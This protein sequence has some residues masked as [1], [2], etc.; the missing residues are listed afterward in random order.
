MNA[1]NRIRSLQMEIR[2]LDPAE[3]DVRFQLAADRS[4]AGL[5]VRGRL[6]GPRCAYAST[7]EVAY[8][9]RDAPLDEPNRLNARAIVPEP[10]LW[11][12]ACPFLYEATVELLEDRNSIDAITMTLGLRTIAISGK[13]F[14]LNGKRF[15][16][17]AIAAVHPTEADLVQARK[18]FNAIVLPVSEDARPLWHLCDQVGLGVFGCIAN[19]S[20]SAPELANHA[21]LLGWIVDEQKSLASAGDELASARVPVGLQIRND[22]AHACPPGANFVMVPGRASEQVQKWGIPVIEISTIH[23]GESL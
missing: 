7:V 5:S 16:P 1:T 23:R 22:S 14:V 20:R 21:C 18:Q 19:E 11:E 12:P 6:V 4:D 8:P 15:E 10:N 2:K 13:S 3:A 9:L 17:K